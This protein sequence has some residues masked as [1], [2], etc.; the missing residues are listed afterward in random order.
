MVTPTKLASRNSWM[1]VPAL[2]K[3][4][5][6]DIHQRGRAAK[7]VHTDSR[8]IQRGDCFIALAGEHFD[9]HDFLPQVL[10]SRPAGVVIAR[11]AGRLEVPEGVFVIEVEDTNRALGAIAAEHRRRHRAKVVGITGSCGKTSTKDMLASILASQVPSVASPSSFN[12]HVGVP[13][14]LLQIRK[15]TSAAV[16]EIGSN[17][18]GEIAALTEI[19]GPDIGIIT[20][21][22]EAHLRGLGD[23][24]GVA[25]E[26][27]SL[28]SGLDPKG[29]AILNADDASCRKIAER[30]ERRTTLIRVDQ[31]ADWFATDVSFHGLGT[32]FLLQ[33]ER[34]VTLQRLGSH[35]VYNALLSIAAAVECG[36]ELDHILQAICSQQ[37]SERRMESRC[38]GDV[39]LFDDTYNMN[40]VS[41]RAALLA[42]AGLQGKGRRVVVFGEMHELGKQ[43]D[44]LHECLGKE[45]AEAELDYLLTIGERAAAIAE[46]AVAGGMSASRVEMV[47]DLPA[48]L[49]HLLVELKAD[50]R[51]LCKASRRV[52]LDRLVDELTRHLE[53]GEKP[54]PLDA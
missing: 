23:V 30:A 6:G 45:V 26:K 2:A 9:A 42:L 8:S 43:S 29:V 40:P 14:S 54:A 53:L 25:E 13:L 18:P 33:G 46:A 37:P 50:D 27:G 47:N 5:G 28:I 34:P 3:A 52:G 7:R 19:A 35:N 1:S 17:A 41:A 21:V 20:C 48:A 36:L 10:A 32:S 11:G 51:V 49:Q 38:V 4:S 15:D 44:R 24:N 12:N 16:I 39:T 22:G 31:E